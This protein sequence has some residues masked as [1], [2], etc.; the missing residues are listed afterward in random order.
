MKRENTTKERNMSEPKIVTR[1]EGISDLA[2][3]YHAVAA[4]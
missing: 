4:T 2:A 1:K 3:E